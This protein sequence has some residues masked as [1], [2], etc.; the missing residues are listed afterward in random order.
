MS[1]ALQMS[2]ERMLNEEEYNSK[3]GAG[4]EAKTLADFQSVAC[5]LS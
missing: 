3:L 5:S 1:T 4:Q 2:T